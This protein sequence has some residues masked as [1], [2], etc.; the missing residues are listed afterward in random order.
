MVYAYIQLHAPEL[1]PPPP[2]RHPRPSGREI[3]DNPYPD[4]EQSYII[5]EQREDE[6]ESDGHIVIIDLQF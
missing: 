6:D 5:E 2:P 1:L 4:Y 3:L